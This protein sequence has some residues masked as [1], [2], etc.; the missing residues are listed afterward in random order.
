MIERVCLSLI[1][2]FLATATVSAQD[3]RWELIYN[4]EDAGITWN[5]DTRIVLP[6][7]AGIKRVWIREMYP[8]NIY[9]TLKEI[10]CS[11]YMYRYIGCTEYTLDKM[12]EGPCYDQSVYAE[13]I[14]IEPESPDELL[15]DALC[16]SSETNGKAF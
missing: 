4:D 16:G 6:G 11:E 2:L 7:S 1:C 10:D 9:E 14:P 12:P 3:T 15:R 8:E 5:I 13:W